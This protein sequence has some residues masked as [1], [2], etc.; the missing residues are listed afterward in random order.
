[1]ASPANDSPA[2]LTFTTS[3]ERY[4]IDA[5]GFRR[6]LSREVI[7][8][9]Q[10]QREQE[11][12]EERLSQ[13]NEIEQTALQIIQEDHESVVARDKAAGA[14]QAKENEMAL[15]LAQEAQQEADSEIAQLSGNHVMSPAVEEIP[16]ETVEAK[17]KRMRK[18]FVCRNGTWLRVKRLKRFHI[19]EKVYVRN[20]A[21]E[22]ISIGVVNKKGGLPAAYLEN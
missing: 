17:P 3:G 9:Q 5:D 14:Y 2:S 1:M 10:A 20:S 22:F 4:S 6:R 15:Q 13:S 8:L 19:G 18:R 21:G 16:E 12:W 7:D 11:Y